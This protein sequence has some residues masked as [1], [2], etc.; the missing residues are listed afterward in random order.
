MLKT[1]KNVYSR[2]LRAEKKAPLVS[3][4][5]L[6]MNLLQQLAPSEESGST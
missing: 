3:R 4:M 6:Y 1:Y 2:L 5:E